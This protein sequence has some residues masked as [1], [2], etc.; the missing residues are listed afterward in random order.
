MKSGLTSKGIAIL[1]LG[2][3][4]GLVAIASW[5]F[6]QTSIHRNGFETKPGWTKGGFD[7]AYEEIAHRIDDRD[8][9]NG[10]A[11]EYIE[12]NAKQGSYAHYVYP[13]GKAPITEE[14]RASLWLRANRAGMRIMARV[15]LPKERD[16]NNVDY[17]LTTYI[18]GD[19]Y[20]QAG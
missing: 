2:L 20:Q 18:A 8:P 15:I 3:I 17:V 14:L 6:A 19:T 13:V 1:G 7:A 4:V 16:P 11:S 5:A 12:I 10:R 9:H